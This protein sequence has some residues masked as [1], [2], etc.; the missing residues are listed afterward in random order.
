MILSCT[1]L[2]LA[3]I[4]RLSRPSTALGALHTRLAA[5]HAKMYLIAWC[6]HFASEMKVFGLAGRVRVYMVMFKAHK[7]G[8]YH[9]N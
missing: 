9:R 4:R 7:Y 8:Q 2:Q 5:F 3:T 6:I 1:G